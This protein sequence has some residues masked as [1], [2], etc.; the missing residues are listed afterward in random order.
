M[1]EGWEYKRLGELCDIVMGQSPMGN[2]INENNGIEFHQ[3]KTN[4][5]DKFLM[6]S[7]I[8]TTSPIRIAE[9]K[10]ILLCVRAP[11]GI[12]N[13]TERQVCIG[14][15]LSSL[16][17]R[18]GLELL[19]LYYCLLSK[20]NY[21]ESHSTGSTFKA[22]SSKVIN[23]TIIQF[24][25]KPTQLSIVSELDKLNELIRI[26]KEQLKDYDALAQSIFYEMF[27]DPVENEKGWEVKKLGELCSKI[28]S[29]ATP[30][31]G[32]ESYK[33][34]GISLIRSLNVYNNEFRRKDLAYIDDEQAAALSNVTLL[35]NDVLLNITGASV[36]R[37]CIVPSDLLPARVNQHVCIIR[38]LDN[39]LVTIF[40]NKVLTN[41]SYQIRLLALARSKGA[42]REALPK[43]VVDSLLV[44]LPPLPLQ[45]FFAQ[46]IEQIEQQKAAI[47][48]T[49]TD[50][51]TLL[52]ARMQYWFD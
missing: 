31:G 22:I 41:I 24:P 2:S 17:P 40:L 52:A 19:Y 38:P 45:H 34:E 11:V 14:R 21:F 33:D 15:G 48:K 9:K 37:C 1:R 46:K 8:Y 49:I 20:H 44:P 26:K 10:T 35:E 6:E 36:A 23:N 12:I 30:R 32:N 16:K 51:E 3:G 43:S 39:V 4:F 47:Q 18:L 28:G 27:G 50:L 25:P 42:T 5:G 13:I 29:G 7:G